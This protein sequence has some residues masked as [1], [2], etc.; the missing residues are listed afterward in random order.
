MVDHIPNIILAAKLPIGCS[1]I[2]IDCGPWCHVRQNDGLQSV[3]VSRIAW[4]LYKKYFFCKH[5]YLKTVFPVRVSTC[6]SIDITKYPALS[7]SRYT[8]FVVFPNEYYCHE[9]IVLI[10]Y[11]ILWSSEG[12]EIFCGIFHVNIQNQIQFLAHFC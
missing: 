7:F 12:E 5:K 9:H 1:T 10:K 6:L 4:S 2:D 11:F 3:S 8:S